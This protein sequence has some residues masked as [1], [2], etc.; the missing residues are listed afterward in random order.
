MDNPARDDS[1]IPH[2]MPEMVVDTRSN[3]YVKS[4]PLSSSMSNQ[5]TWTYLYDWISIDRV[6]ITA[7]IER[8]MRT[9]ETKTKEMRDMTFPGLKLLVMMPTNVPVR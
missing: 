5:S 3:V 7:G 9:Y 2:P 1:K 4:V 6:P 8:T